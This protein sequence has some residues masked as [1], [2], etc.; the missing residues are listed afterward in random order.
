MMLLNESV[1]AK[2]LIEVEMP[3]K[4]IQNQEIIGDGSAHKP[5]F[6]SSLFQPALVI[7]ISSAWLYLVGTNYVNSFL[8]QLGLLPSTVELSVQQ[9]LIFGFAP[10]LAII[11]IILLSLTVGLEEIINRKQAL[12]ANVIWLVAGIFDLYYFVKLF[13]NSDLFALV[14]ATISILNYVVLVRG[15]R[16]TWGIILNSKIFVRIINIFILSGLILFASSYL[17]RLSATDSIENPAPGTATI[18]LKWKEKSVPP[19]LQDRKLFFIFYQNGNYYVTPFEKPFPKSPRV[20]V[21]PEIEI[22]YA[23]SSKTE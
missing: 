21:I 7:S 23:I 19:E 6:I 8:S 16:N 12:V 13:P 4:K 15:K 14:L 18:Q 22:Q 17:G 20:F 2:K 5:Q 3:R 9:Y 11:P 1:I 10:I